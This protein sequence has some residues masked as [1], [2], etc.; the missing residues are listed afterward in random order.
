MVS[1]L[2]GINRRCKMK[3]RSIRW[4]AEFIGLVIFLACAVLAFCAA[5]TNCFG[6]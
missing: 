2:T 6:G 4:E 5:A 1:E 3:R